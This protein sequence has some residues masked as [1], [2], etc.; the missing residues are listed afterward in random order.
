[1]RKTRKRF[2][3][4]VVTYDFSEQRVYVNGQRRMKSEL[5]G[6]IFSN[7]DPASSLL[8]GNEAPSNRP[9]LGKLFLAAIYNRALS[10]QEVLKNYMAGRVFESKVGPSDKRVR[11]GLVALY[12]FTEEQGDWI[13]DQSGKLPSADL[14]ILT[15]LLQIIN[16]RFLVGLSEEFNFKDVILNMIIFIPFGFFLNAAMR[17]RYGPSPQIAAFV[18]ILG[19]LFTFTIESLQ[20]FS[21][22]RFSSMADLL[23]NMIGTV[24]GIMIDKSYILHFK[25]SLKITRRA[26]TS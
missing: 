13:L 16:Q 18:F 4:I 12:L 21:I 1:M 7:W 17:I 5:P 9:W 19:T 14:K 3:H 2:P 23:S 10:E 8:F 6:G 25:M 26:S 22:T 24:L 20:Y 11:D 15:G